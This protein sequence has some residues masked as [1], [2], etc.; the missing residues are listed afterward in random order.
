MPRLIVHLFLHGILAA[1]TG[2]ASAQEFPVKPIRVITAEV[3]GS[4]DFV[5]RII[6]QGLPGILG[7]Q[8]IVENR[9]GGGGIIAAQLVIKA[10]R[11][12]YTLLLYSDGTWTLP[13]IQNVP[14]DPIS[15]FAPITVADRFPNILAVHPS[16][17]VKSVKDLIALAKARPGQLAYAS[18]GTGSSSHLGG[19]MLKAM[20]GVNIVR[21]PYKGTAPAMIDLISGQEQLMIATLG[22]LAP[23][24]KAGR[25]RALAVT[26]AQP[27]ALAP[28]LPTVAAA[29][30]PGY[31][32]EAKHAV[33]A[34]AGTPRAIVIRLNEEIVRLLNKSETKEKLF[35]AGGEV[36]GN[37]PEQFTAM[38]KSDMTRLGKL[39]KEA[40]IRAD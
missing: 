29:G 15:D 23:H 24:L 28:G 1:R 11:D 35:N 17:P 6:A 8:V 14:Y 20:A 18:G 10:P 36:I 40:G 33:F 38:M 16:L 19:E 26:S 31:E 32:S 2:V 3:G 9:A 7:Q 4:S 30:L 22:G 21:V 25:V 13:L 5:A 37:S 27:T 34:P 12:G 39:F